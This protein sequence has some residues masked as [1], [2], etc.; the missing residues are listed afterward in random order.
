MQHT[1]TFCSLS[2]AGSA[3][4]ASCCLEAVGQPARPAAWRWQAEWRPSGHERRAPPG[5]SA[6]GKRTGRA[7]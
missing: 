5:A 7:P 4:A 6:G 1:A 2:I 3:M